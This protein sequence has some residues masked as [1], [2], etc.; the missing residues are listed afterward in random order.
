MRQ[1]RSGGTRYIFASPGLA[2]RRR[3]H[4]TSNVRPRS[5]RSAVCSPSFKSSRSAGFNRC[6]TGDDRREFAQLL[7]SKGGESNEYES[8]ARVQGFSARVTTVA[9]ERVYEASSSVSPLIAGALARWSE[10][11]YCLGK[12]YEHQHKVILTPYMC[13]EFSRRARHEAQVCGSSLQSC[14]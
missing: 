7:V 2:H 8:A 4:L 14:I 10:V 9:R 13:L 5:E 1:A 12:A 11:S 6:G 3:S